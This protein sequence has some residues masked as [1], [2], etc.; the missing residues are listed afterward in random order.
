MRFEGTL[1]KEGKYWAVQ[2]APMGVHTQGRSKK[3]ALEMAK[4]AIET[5]VDKEGFNVL[6][7]LIGET[8]FAVS[9]KDEKI[10]IGAILKRK[11]ILQGLTAQQVA[12]SMHQKSATGYL[13]YEQGKISLSLKKLGEILIAMNPAN[14]PVIKI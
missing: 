10:L 14:K 11:R 9:A 2:F 5:L 8:F 1:H 4:D 13:R 12:K 7:E 3:E 6:V